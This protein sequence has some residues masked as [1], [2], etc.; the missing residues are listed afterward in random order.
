MIGLS[1]LKHTEHA[2]ISEYFPTGHSHKLYIYIVSCNITIALP[3][4]HHHRKLGASTYVTIDYQS[5]RVKPGQQG[6][7]RRYSSVIPCYLGM[8]GVGPLLHKGP[9][10]RA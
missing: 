9:F 3:P 5:D 8:W 4:D 10:T 1:W 2:I 6:D 7:A